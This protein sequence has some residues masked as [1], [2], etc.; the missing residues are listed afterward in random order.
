[1]CIISGRELHVTELHLWLF[2][3]LPELLLRSGFGFHSAWARRGWTCFCLLRQRLFYTGLYLF[4]FF[5]KYIFITLDF[6]IYQKDYTTLDLLHW[7]RFDFLK[8]D[9]H[10]FNYH[11]KQY[12]SIFVWDRFRVCKIF[13]WELGYTKYTKCESSWILEGETKQAVHNGILQTR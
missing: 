6:I 11:G 10:Y 5:W 8:E 4:W 2:L 12:F 3:D 1:M 9:Y 13:Q 7:I